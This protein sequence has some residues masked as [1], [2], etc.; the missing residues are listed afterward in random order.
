MPQHP[1]W[2]PGWHTW[3]TNCSAW[4]WCWL[5]WPRWAAAKYNKTASKSPLGMLAAKVRVSGGWT[6]LQTGLIKWGERLYYWSGERCAVC[7]VCVPSPVPWPHSLTHM[8]ALSPGETSELGAWLA[9]GDCCRKRWG[10]HSPSCC[11][12]PAD[13]SSRCC[14]CSASIAVPAISACSPFGKCLLFL[15]VA[16]HRCFRA[17]VPH[18]VTKAL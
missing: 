5:W 12:L 7:C 15:Q 11:C 14:C 3:D 6:G 17:S 10:C 4:C 13:L 1:I 16:D 18:L 9:L 2:H 8:H